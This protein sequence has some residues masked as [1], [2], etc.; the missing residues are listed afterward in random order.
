MCYI[1]RFAKQPKV[2]VESMTIGCMYVYT[3]LLIHTHAVASVVY[4]EQS[5]SIARD[6]LIMRNKARIAGM[7]I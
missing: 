6:E 2:S 4:A 3:H 5:V 7:A 1:D